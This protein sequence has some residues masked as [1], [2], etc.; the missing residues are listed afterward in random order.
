MAGG[1][2][3]S[4]EEAWHSIEVEQ[5]L[6]KLETSR[7]GLT[8][9]EAKNRFQVH[10]ANELE[11]EAKS[12][13]LAMLLGQ[14]RSPLVAVLVVAALISFFVDEYIDMIV[15]IVVIALNAIIGF[16]Q[17]YKAEAALQALKTLAAPEAEVVREA[18]EMRIKAKEIVVGDVIALEAGT[19]VPADARILEA[20]N[21]E[22]DESML[23]GE[24]LP[25]RKMNSPLERDLAVADRVNMVFS[26]T[27]VTRGRGKAVVASTGMK[28][29]IGKIAKL[30]KDTEKAATPI[31]K[32]T[33]DLS[34]KLGLFALVASGLI[35][36]I[37]LL[38]GV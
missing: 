8:S 4:G 5:V 15:I 36:A 27:I 28:T 20:M 6:L 24:S 32:Q 11:E 9:V 35:L 7:Q 33:A 21:L 30:I 37:S 18:V 38:R 22:I 12:S 14:L 29:E 19:K 25:V 13:K 26:G 34:T 17:E 2:V 3:L 23:T 31:Q 1:A 10:G 16:F